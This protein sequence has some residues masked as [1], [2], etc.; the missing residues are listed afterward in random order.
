VNGVAVLRG[1]KLSKWE[2]SVIYG[3]CDKNAAENE[4]LARLKEDRNER[5]REGGIAVEEG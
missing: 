1:E 2:T 3:Q 4:R 5:T